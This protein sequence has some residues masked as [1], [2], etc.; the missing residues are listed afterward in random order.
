M[1]KTYS[2]FLDFSILIGSN[3]DIGVDRVIVEGLIL[4]GIILSKEFKE[5]IKILSKLSKFSKFSGLA[6][7]IELDI[8]LRI[9]FTAS[10]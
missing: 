10:K 2:F 9:G 7:R 1:K 4:Y 5:S 8:G 6:L 3:I